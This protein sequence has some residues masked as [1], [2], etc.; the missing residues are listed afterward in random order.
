M[1]VEYK[2]VSI[3]NSNKLP[4]R[5]LIRED[6]MDKEKIQINDVICIV[7]NICDE[8]FSECLGCPLYKH[9][10]NGLGGWQRQ[11]YLWQVLD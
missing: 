1:A 7:K 11:P 3:I 5:I 8:H 10:C 4:T 9:I 2:L 6:N